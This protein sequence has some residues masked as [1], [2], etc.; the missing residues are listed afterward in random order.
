M[1][2]SKGLCSNTVA[3]LYHDQ[4]AKIL[5]VYHSVIKVLYDK[6]ILNSVI[7]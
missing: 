4:Q 3:F 6:S 2:L 5:M 7:M 1:R